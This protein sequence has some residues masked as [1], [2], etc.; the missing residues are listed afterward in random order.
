MNDEKGTSG[1]TTIF[2]WRTTT[3]DDDFT[4]VTNTTDTNATHEW[5]WRWFFCTINLW[6]NNDENMTPIFQHRIEHDDDERIRRRIVANDEQMTNKLTIAHISVFLSI[7][8]TE[9]C[10]RKQI[11]I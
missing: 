9:T 10:Y 1:Y 8:K 5:R 6:R 7:Y 11:F 3:A 4:N 2:K